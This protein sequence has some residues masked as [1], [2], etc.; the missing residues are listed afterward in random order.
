MIASPRWKHFRLLALDGTLVNLG[1]WPSAGKH[2]GTAKGSRGGRVPAAAI[3]PCLHRGPC[4]VSVCL[5]PQTSGRED[6]GRAACSPC[7]RTTCCPRIAASELRPV[8]SHPRARG[9]FAIRQI[10]Q[11]VP[12]VSARWAP[13]TPARYAPT[14]RKWRKLGLPEAMELRRIVYQVRGFRPAAVI[15]NVTDP[16]DL[17]RPSGSA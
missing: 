7:A 5:G 1:G 10:A 15:T 13:T 11:G 12:S 2:Y 16:T 14:D 6:H 9:G 17:A 3:D 4:P 8:L